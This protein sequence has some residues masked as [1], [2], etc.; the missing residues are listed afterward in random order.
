MSTEAPVKR[1]AIEP[2]IP[3]PTVPISIVASL[4]SVSENSDP[5]LGLFAACV[6]SK[7]RLSVASAASS[8]ETATANVVAIGESIDDILKTA[9]ENHVWDAKEFANV[10]AAWND[11]FK[12]FNPGSTVVP[13]AMRYWQ[14]FGCVKA[15]VTLGIPDL[16]RIAVK[17]WMALFGTAF[18]V[19]KA[20]IT[21]N[22]RTGWADWLKVALPL[23]RTGPD[24]MS[25]SSL[26]ASV[27]AQANA[28]HASDSTIHNAPKTSKK[29]KPSKPPVP[30]VGK[31]PV[32]PVGKPPVP[33][34][35]KQIDPIDAIAAPP[36]NPFSAMVSA[37]QSGDAKTR[38]NMAIACGLAIVKAGDDDAIMALYKTI[39]GDVAR[40]RDAKKLAIA[41]VA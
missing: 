16:D 4:V 26:V 39:S 11:A 2:I 33:P 38:S 1:L 14:V 37:M 25:F 28:L 23:N 18:S 27:V 9:K 36:V 15:S 13:D 29:D 5:L 6:S 7:I 41:N 10:I 3:V 8:L 22:V 35:G 21:V 40:I 12:A 30:P 20:D 17:R 24:S 31:P 32:P 34:V 19:S